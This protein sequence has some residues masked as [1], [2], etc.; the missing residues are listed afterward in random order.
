MAFMGDLNQSCLSSG[1]G[2]N[3]VAVDSENKRN[4]NGLLRVETSLSG[5]LL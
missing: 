4:T 5:V 1:G 2:G 3:L